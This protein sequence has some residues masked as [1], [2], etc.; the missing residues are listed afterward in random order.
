MTQVILLPFERQNYAKENFVGSCP[1]TRTCHY[2]ALLAPCAISCIE[3]NVRM[4][5]FGGFLFDSGSG[6]PCGVLSSFPSYRNAVTHRRWYGRLRGTVG[7][8]KI[9]KRKFS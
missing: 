1:L 8:K 9:G 4:A 2:F 6:A 5:K 3:T 7:C